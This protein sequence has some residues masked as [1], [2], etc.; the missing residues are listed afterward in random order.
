MGKGMGKR[1]GESLWPDRGE[2]GDWA[3]F[4]AMGREV[5]KE[6]GTLRDSLGLPGREGGRDGDSLWPVYGGI[7][8]REF[9]YQGEGGVEGRG[10]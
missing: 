9:F 1:D 8:A 4:L 5:G 3:V 2:K 10:S 6:T 7:E